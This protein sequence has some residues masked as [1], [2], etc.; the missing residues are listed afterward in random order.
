V[1]HFEKYATDYVI[2]DPVQFVVSEAARIQS[3]YPKVMVAPLLYA[4]EDDRLTQ[5]TEGR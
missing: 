4:V 5:I 1:H 2:G 3:Y